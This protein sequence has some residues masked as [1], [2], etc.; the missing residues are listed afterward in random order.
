MPFYTGSPDKPLTA[1]PMHSLG[2][3]QPPSVV[4]GDLPQPERDAVVADLEADLRGR[5]NWAW[6]PP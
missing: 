6:C 2:S 4:A 1:W 3:E 5:P